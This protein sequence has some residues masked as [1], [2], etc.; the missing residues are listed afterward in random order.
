MVIARTGRISQSLP[1]A[2]LHTGVRVSSQNCRSLSSSVQT[3]KDC[4][5]LLPNAVLIET[6]AASRPRIMRTCLKI[7]WES[8]DNRINS[9]DPHEWLLQLKA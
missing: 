6:S 8:A 5:R 2:A 7:M 9:I 1:Y 4:N 3:R